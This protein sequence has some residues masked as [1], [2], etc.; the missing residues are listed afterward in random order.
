MPSK[1][2]LIWS[3]RLGGLGEDGVG[4]GLR[5]EVHGSVEGRGVILR[6]EPLGVPLGDGLVLHP[7]G[8][9]LVEPEVVPPLHGD[10]VAEP[11]VR[12]LVGDDGGDA[13]LGVDAG[14]LIDEE[15]GLAIGDAAEVLHGAGLEVGQADEVELGPWGT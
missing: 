4:G 1:S 15:V 2:S 14:V 12:H 8:E 5:V 6:V 3:G 7:G 13:L 11:L 10:H 9:A